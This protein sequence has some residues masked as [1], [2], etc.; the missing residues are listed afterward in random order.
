MA[1]GPD[2]VTF[3]PILIS[4]VWA[5]A[6]FG[7]GDGVCARGGLGVQAPITKPVRSAKNNYTIGYFFY[8]FVL[9]V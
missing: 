8:A 3:N 9:L 6:G 7:F 1:A 2:R 4:P 5:D